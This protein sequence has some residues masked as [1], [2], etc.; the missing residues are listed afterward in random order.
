MMLQQQSPLVQLPMDAKA[1][2]LLLLAACRG[3]S[4]REH[5]APA[6]TARLAC[7]QSANTVCP[8]I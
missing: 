4:A 2:K 3:C 1:G 6:L 5:M 8:A 7:P